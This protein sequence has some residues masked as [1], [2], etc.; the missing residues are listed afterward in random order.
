MIVQQT[1]TAEGGLEMLLIEHVRRL[2]RWEHVFG[3]ATALSSF[4]RLYTSIANR[5]RWL[6]SGQAKQCF[7]NATAIALVRDDV[8][9]VEGFALDPGI[10]IP[11]EHAWLVDDNGHV[12]DPTWDE[13]RGHLYYGVPFEKDFVATMM[14]QSGGECGVLDHRLMRQYARSE[15]Q[16]ERGVRGNLKSSA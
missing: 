8:T 12:I 16:F 7:L 11:V 9:Y 5:P 6:L 13:S 14:K 4:G 3:P 2:A 15:Q 1:A 10:P